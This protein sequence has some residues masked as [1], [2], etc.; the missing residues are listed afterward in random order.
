[1]SPARLIDPTATRH[2]PRA[3]A[4]ALRAE[5]PRIAL[6]D[7]MLN[8]RGMWG[9]GILDAVEEHLRV[10]LKGAV[11]GR[12]SINPL[13]P[14]APDRWSAAIQDRYDA[15]V[16]AAGDCVTCTTRGVRV[17]IATEELDVP[18]V[19]VCTEAVLETVQGAAEVNRLPSLRRVPVTTSLFGRSR[20]EIAAVVRDDVE[21]VVNA[22]TER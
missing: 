22:L 2:A 7:G 13:N 4:P 3:A 17:A 16:V 6:V 20:E 19:L 10:Q 21:S 9:Q 18:A 12:E 14:E 15:V 11:F 1:M 8:K 5:H